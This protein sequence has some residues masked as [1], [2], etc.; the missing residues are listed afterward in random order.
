LVKN[1]DYENYDLSEA[2]FELYA[3][4][5][6]KD[7][8]DAM[9]EMLKNQIA[10]EN[11]NRISNLRKIFSGKKVLVLGPS[12]ISKSIKLED[13]DLIAVSNTKLI[14]VTNNLV[15]DDSNFVIFINQ[16]YFY[17][18]KF[19]LIDEAKTVSA[20]FVKPSVIDSSFPKFLIPNGLMFND[21]GPMGVQNILYSIY[22]GEAKSI[23]VTGVTGYLGEKI[24]RQGIKTYSGNKQHISNNIR[25]HE[26]IGNFSF[27]KNFVDLDLCS[28]DETFLKIFKND[29][30][31]YCKNLDE[32]YS[33]YLFKRIDIRKLHSN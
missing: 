8:K 10:N 11:D 27:I 24:H 31:N 17:R 20:I 23:F 26:P 12:K 15:F 6:K 29:I 14:T 21:C 33:N 1:L 30:K 2:K 4:S 16:G 13:F 3:Y 5:N 25:N 9:V 32:L 18:N 19:K 7:K 28:G 22:A